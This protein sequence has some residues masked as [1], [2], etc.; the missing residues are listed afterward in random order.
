MSELPE[1][2]PEQRGP[3]A[4]EEQRTEKPLH[5]AFTLVGSTSA[6]MV[7]ATDPA[8]PAVDKLSVA[9]A[10]VAQA[11]GDM[12]QLFPKEFVYS[13]DDRV[14]VTTRAQ[15]DG[16][17][18]AADDQLSMR[19]LIDPGGVLA[20]Q[21][22]RDTETGEW[23]ITVPLKV[24]AE[25][26]TRMIAR[27]LGDAYAATHPDAPS[28]AM[29]ELDALSLLWNRATA[30]SA[31]AVDQGDGLGARVWGQEA[32]RLSGEFRII[33]VQEGIVSAHGEPDTGSRTARETAWPTM[34]DHTRRLATLQAD[35][36]LPVLLSAATDFRADY[37]RLDNLV[38]FLETVPERADREAF[39]HE[40]FP[41]AVDASAMVGEFKEVYKGAM[42]GQSNEGA[43]PPQVEQAANGTIASLGRELDG[44][45]DYVADWAEREG[46][47]ER[48]GFTVE[49]AVALGEQWFLHDHRAIKARLDEIVQDVWREYG[50]AFGADEGVEFGY[51][52]S[53]STGQRGPHKAGVHTDL[54]DFDL[55]LYIVDR[56]RFDA[57]YP[58]IM[59]EN[60]TLYSRGKIMP[61]QK[62]TPDLCEL[63]EKIA[64]RL[65]DEFPDNP[66]LAQSTVALRREFPHR[67]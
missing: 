7:R 2:N 49:Q 42:P 33:A 14:T 62:L 30:F 27:S 5:Q 66:S 40:A 52:G 13:N 10:M 55:D 4:T 9:R 11:F 32:Q 8:D 26:A 12:P 53:M 31:I 58:R 46:V 22:Y 18:Q 23:S 25:G 19:V 67:A 37:N 3:E 47:L 6:D 65:R 59:A 50:L 54:Y 57:E 28:G 43:L 24:T 17:R 39:A 44:L 16:T 51:V 41:R 1:Q 21:T 20:P 34:S 45:F 38:R 60:P 61:D 15:N 35:A 64:A 63:S 29:R 56:H 48:T 36:E